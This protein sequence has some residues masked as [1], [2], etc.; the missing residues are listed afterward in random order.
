MVIES[1][2]WGS[3]RMKSKGAYVN[4]LIKGYPVYKNAFNRMDTLESNKDIELLMEVFS[5]VKDKN[6]KPAIMALNNVVVNPDFKKIKESDFKQYYF[7]PFTETL[8]RYPAHDQVY[9]LLKIGVNQGLFRPQ[10]HGR[11]HLNIGRWM[12]DLRLGKKP[13][14][15]A[16]EHQM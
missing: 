2:D 7:K 6:G 12:R 10:Y 1:D 16:F 5:S 15:D 8:K 11:E 14:L 4:L 9:N 13:L 3:I